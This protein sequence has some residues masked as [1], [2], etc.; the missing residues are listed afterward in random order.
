MSLA[1]NSEVEADFYA[2][3]DQDDIWDEKKLE[4]ALNS[5]AAY[6]ESLPILYCSRTTLVN[7]ENEFI[8][9]SPLHTKAPSFQNALTQNIGGGNTMVFNSAAMRLI[10]QVSVPDSTISHDWWIYL[11]VSACGGKVIYDRTPFVRYRQHKENAIGGKARFAAR[12]KRLLSGAI[13][14]SNEQNLKALDRVLPFMP[15]HHRTLIA[16]FQAA[17]QAPTLL[18]LRRLRSLGLYRQSTIGSLGFGLAAL[19]NKV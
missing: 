9:F 1:L 17:R 7:A 8:G 4:R 12:M 3:C 19:L 10:R 11:V 18:R 5:L 13:R 6:P 2:F 16:N 14:E 15:P